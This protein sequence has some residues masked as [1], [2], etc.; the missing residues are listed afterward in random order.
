MQGDSWLLRCYSDGT[1]HARS[2]FS[3]YSCFFLPSYVFYDS[4][5]RMRCRDLVI[6]FFKKNLRLVF[7]FGEF[8]GYDYGEFIGSV[9]GSDVRLSAD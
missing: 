7:R 3:R 5:R 8:M 2:K 9:K 1:P 4:P 6:L